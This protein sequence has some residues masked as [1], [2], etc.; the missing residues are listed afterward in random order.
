MIQ[1]RALKWSPYSKPLYPP[2]L[3]NTGVSHQEQELP[4][5]MSSLQAP[6]LSPPVLNSQLN[7]IHWARQLYRAAPPGP[8]DNSYQQLS[9]EFLMV[10]LTDHC[11]TV[12][13]CILSLP[14]HGWWGQ[15]KMAKWDTAAAAAAGTA[16]PRKWA[17]VGAGVVILMLYRGVNVCAKWNKAQLSEINL[18]DDTGTQNRWGWQGPQEIIWY[19]ASAPAGPART[20][21]PGHCCQGLSIF[22]AGDFT[23]PLSNSLQCLTIFTVNALLC[24]DG[25]SHVSVCPHCLCPVSGNVQPAPDEWSV[26]S[27]CEFWIHGSLHGHSNQPNE[28]TCTTSLRGT[29]FFPSFL[30]TPFQYPVQFIRKS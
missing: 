15:W 14:W 6:K 25:V 12:P 21:C 5:Y 11:V 10:L 3:L 28:E 1:A 24:S 13:F 16:V 4:S 26:N 9:S 23:T 22:P 2:C 18:W 17:V 8:G 20:G 29:V 30:S 27:H 7:I 19:N